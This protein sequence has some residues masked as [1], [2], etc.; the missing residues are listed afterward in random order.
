LI[1]FQSS[2]VKAKNQRTELHN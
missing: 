2:F 1:C